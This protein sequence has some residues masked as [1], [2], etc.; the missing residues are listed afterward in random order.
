MN[1]KKAIY[2]ILVLGGGLTAIVG[3]KKAYD[4]FKEP[5]FKKLESS[6]SLLNEL[7]DTII[8]GGS[9]PGAKEAS[10][11]SFIILMIKDC[12]NRKDQN[13]FIKGI[14]ELIYHC[15][16]RYGKLFEACD[17]DQRKA[18]LLHFEKK[19]ITN[20]RI[21]AKVKERLLG[22]SFFATLKKYVV[23]G[24]CT[25]KPGAT[26]ALRYDPVPGQY[27]ACISLENKTAW[28]TF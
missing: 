6:L 25:S 15:V 7:S 17:V 23:L 4:L 13:N 3:S 21:I 11:G 22:Q 27:K 19:E 18:V 28:A 12:T 24:Y 8:P 26:N 2:R 20:N 14:D 9:I 1:R 16:T 5:D 10:V